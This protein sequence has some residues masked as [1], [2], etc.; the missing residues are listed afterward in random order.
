M[1]KSPLQEALIK[2]SSLAY[3]LYKLSDHPTNTMLLQFIIEEIESAKK[4]L[5]KIVRY[6]RRFLPNH[7]SASGTY[8]ES[9]A[10]GTV[11]FCYRDGSKI[12]KSETVKWLEENR[13]ETFDHH[14]QS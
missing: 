7:G 2:A 5:Q 1:N 9:Y 11:S 13:E 8:W 4:K 12:S 6:P 3:E 10:D 14:E